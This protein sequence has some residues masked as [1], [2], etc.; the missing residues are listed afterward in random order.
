MIKKNLK[1]LILLIVLAGG[2]YLYNGPFKAWQ[3]KRQAPDNFLASVNI[4]E[5][6]KIEVVRSGKTV[7]LVK[8][9]ENWKII[10]EG[11]F[12]ASKKEVESMK[13][14]F[15]KAKEAK[16]EL[17]SNNKDKKDDFDL[18][19]ENGTEV[20]LSKGDKVMLQFMIGKMTSDFSGVFLGREEDDK[21]YSVSA[22][23]R[24]AFSPYEWR[25]LAIFNFSKDKISRMRFQYPDRQF[26]MERKDGKWAGTAPA[27]F[28][29]NQDKM[30]EFLIAMS[31][32]QA[33]AIPAQKFAGTDLEKNLMI[34]EAEGSGEK[35]AL[36]V[37]KDTGQGQFYAKRGDSDNIYLISK[38]S[39]D[40]FNKKVEDF[41]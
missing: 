36:M 30:D 20:K 19:K 27:G 5:A 16:L 23:L 2:I 14:E 37:G 31:Q 7:T 21:S 10:G 29:A 40:A 8:E 28:S 33:E 38:L 15:N 1:L 32:L 11:N 3:E 9:G 17:A 26:T 25:D 18:V 34:I 6:D 35:Y 41:K 22:E 4:D 24:G 12:Y 39:R 13:A